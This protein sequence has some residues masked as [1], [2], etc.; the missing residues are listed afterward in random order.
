MNENALT[1]EQAREKFGAM[2][3]NSWDVAIDKRPV[4]VVDN[5]SYEFRAGWSVNEDGSSPTEPYIIEKN[6]IGKPKT[7][8]REIDSMHI[9]GS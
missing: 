4:L 1:A 5:G 8:Q 9:V 2:I 6:Q 7:L 3:K